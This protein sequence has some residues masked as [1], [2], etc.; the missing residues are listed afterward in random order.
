MST[1]PGSAVVVN[2]I[3]KS[4]GEKTAVNDISFTV[5]TGEIFGLIGPNGAG[6]TS[7][8]RM[9]MNIIRPD[10]GEVAILGKRL[11]EASKNQ[12]GYLPEERGLYR[13]LSVIDSILYL[14]TLKGMARRAAESK[15]D[16]LL[17]QTGMLPHKNKKIEELSKGMGQIIQFIV[18]IIHDPK[19]V[20]LDE[21]FSGLDPANTELLKEMI[22]NLK[23]QGTT[24]IL[25]T[26]GMNDVEE[27]CDR[28]LMINNGRSVLYGNLN[29]IKSR[30]R[31]NS[32]LLDVAGEL[33]E[34]PGVITKNAHKDYVELVLD[35]D[36]TPQQLLE[37]LVSS[38]I[39]IKRFEIATPTLNEIFLK[40]VG[41]SHE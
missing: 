4:Y 36:T 39:T 16:D 13:K 18:T 19:L 30:Y 27:L 40:I 6:K 32:V 14:A 28:L 29:E 26:H 15:A 8:I 25:S 38:G 21:P 2:H 3:F 31:H 5:N 24:V 34:V 22:S 10:A 17:R 7:T 1:F 11:S 41:A 12:I 37:R 35:G 33:G 20:I 9:I 23:R